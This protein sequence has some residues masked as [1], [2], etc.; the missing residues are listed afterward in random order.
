MEI[1][2]NPFDS[3]IS[4]FSNVSLYLENTSDLELMEVKNQTERDTKSAE[5]INCDFNN[6]VSDISH[7]SNKISRDDKLMKTLRESLP[8]SD[9]IIL[10]HNLQADCVNSIKQIY[11]VNSRFVHSLDR[12]DLWDPK[13]ESLCSS[14][15]KENTR[16][17]SEA[18]NIKDCML[19]NMKHMKIE[20]Y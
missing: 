16:E 7:A 4:S 14:I 12:K 17:I 11:N 6:S 13:L 20:I 19:Y 5:N 10:P 18:N 8:K 9:F 2:D 1:D 3:I 15:R